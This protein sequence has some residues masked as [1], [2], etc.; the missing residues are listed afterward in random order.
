[1]I[2]EKSK[3]LKEAKEENLSVP[4]KQQV[5][6]EITKK[7]ALGERFECVSC[8]E[9]ALSEITTH[10][11]TRKEEKCP[12]KKRKK[13]FKFAREQPK[14]VIVEEVTKE[15]TTQQAGQGLC[16]ARAHRV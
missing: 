3:E 1:M 6:K 14:R 15:F 5:E 16:N 8:P 2:R 10:H 11:N 9:S 13:R 12:E 4:R 7:I